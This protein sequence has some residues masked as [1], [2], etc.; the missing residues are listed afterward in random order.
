VVGGKR[1]L[2]QYRE[3]RRRASEG[4]KFPGFHF[5][6][7]KGNV[8]DVVADLHQER[9]PKRRRTE[10]TVTA[11]I[12]QELLQHVFVKSDSRLSAQQMVTFSENVILRATNLGL[13][14]LRRAETAPASGLRETDR[15]RTPP[16]TPPGHS[17][18]SSQ[19]KSR[20][21]HPL[22]TPHS[23]YPGTSTLHDDKSGPQWIGSPDHFEEGSSPSASTEQLSQRRHSVSQQ[24]G[25]QLSPLKVT[26][27]AKTHTWDEPRADSW[28]DERSANPIPM[29]SRVGTDRS[30]QDQTAAA[31][32]RAQTLGRL[33]S[34]PT[35]S[36]SQV[37]SE[38]EYSSPPEPHKSPSLLPHLTI[39]E[40]RDWVAEVKAANSGIKNKLKRRVSA[41]PIKELPHETEF[42]EELSE[43]DHVGILPPRCSCFMLT[44]VSDFRS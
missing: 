17:R 23:S 15:P 31:F 4:S 35:K 3:H 19:R 44:Q 39:N 34:T 21:P 26:P 8:S 14:S 36:P 43:R 2:K 20:R 5:H 24:K 13:G 9:W 29:R 38:Q 10:D 42:L 6:D 22:H 33:E 16:N 28:T 25:R 27:A 1:E 40:L 37:H 7:N 12:W 32:N 11:C 41:I 18:S 30:S